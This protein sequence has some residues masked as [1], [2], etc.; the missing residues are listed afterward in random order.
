MWRVAAFAGST[1]VGGAFAGKTGVRSMNG[2]ED[3]GVEMFTHVRLIS[4]K[5]PF[6]SPLNHLRR[7]GNFY[8]F[9]FRILTLQTLTLAV[10]SNTSG[11]HE[12]PVSGD[13][14]QSP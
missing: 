10:W 14:G 5:G 13:T 9:V 8:S 2:V 1:E 7:T 3:D 12:L 11:F 6:W 4:P